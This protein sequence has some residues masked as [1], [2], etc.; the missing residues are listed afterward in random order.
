MFF[1]ES[2]CSENWSKKSFR[3]L[4]VKI[5]VKIKIKVKIYTTCSHYFVNQL[6]CITFKPFEGLEITIT[7]FRSSTGSMSSEHAGFFAL[8]YC[9]YSAYQN[10]LIDIDFDETDMSD[11]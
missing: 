4:K 8:F 9:N 2:F 11:Y 3:E 5:E 1:L 10:Q 6:S 7:D